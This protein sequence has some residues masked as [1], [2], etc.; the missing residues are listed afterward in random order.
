MSRTLSVRID[1]LHLQRPF[2]IS[3]GTRSDARVVVAEVTDGATTGRGECVPYSHNRETP[4]TV[5]EALLRQEAAVAAGIDRHA[6]QELMPPGAARNALDGALWDL[7]A[8]R[9]G[10]RAWDIAGLQAPNSVVT[11]FT[12]SLDTPERMADAARAAADLPLLKL[13]LTGRGDLERVAAV[14][15]AAPESRIIVD[16]NEAWSAEDLA[17]LPPRLAELGV[18][19]IEQPVP[20]GA[21]EILADYR[22]PIALCADEACHDRSDLD[23]VTGRYEMV[24]IKLDKAGGLTEALALAEAARARGLGIMVGCMLG[25]SL[26]M[27]PAMLVAEGADIVDLDGPLWLADDRSPPLQITEGRMSPPEA[28]LWG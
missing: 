20:A 23:R 2:T 9:T 18:A 24:N 19:M 1:T 17:T 14:R 8:K 13:K 27:A 26:A 11:A 28:T 5:T 7:E 4:A 15:A 25:S 22:G 21:D 16:A 10:R 6:L 3:R 12:I